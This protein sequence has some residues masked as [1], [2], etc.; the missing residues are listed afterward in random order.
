MK[1]LLLI[2]VCAWFVMTDA[3][4]QKEYRVSGKVETL[5]G[6]TLPGAHVKLTDTK[7]TDR[8]IGAST[9]ADG[10][11]S[12]PVLQGT[13]QM[14]I[15]FVGYVTYVSNVNVKG[16][17]HLPVVTLGE[18]AQLMDEVV[19]TARTVTYHSNGYVAEISKNPFYKNQDMNAILRM[20]PG[21]RV[22][23]QGLEAYGNS[24]SKVYLN[25]RELRLRG[26]ELLDY[27]QTIEGKNVKQMEVVAA[28][29]VEEDA[30]STGLA[31][32][33]ITTINPET[34]GLL[35]IGG[36][37]NYRGPNHIYGGDMNLQWRINKKWGVYGRFSKNKSN[38]ES[39]NRSETHFYETDH[40][41][42]GETEDRSKKS[43]I[44]GALGVT[45]DW[46]EN[47]LFSIEGTYNSLPSTTQGWDDTRHWNGQT[48]ENL[49]RGSSLS[50]GKVDFLNLSFLYLH[51]FG[52][53]GELTF[54]AEAYKRED[55]DK[56]ER[57]Y[58]YA[59]GE[60]QESSFLGEESNTL[61]TLKV[62]YTH[63]FSSVKGKLDAGLK[64]QW[65]ENDNYN[66]YLAFVNGQKDEYGSYMD[67]Y[68]YKDQVYAAYAKYSFDWKKFKFN[69]GV[70]VEHNRV[71]PYSAINPERNVRSNYTD[72][73]PEAGISYFIDKEKGHNTSLS[74][75]KG[76]QRPLMG[77]LNPVVLRQGEYNYYMGNPL[78]KPYATHHFSWTTHLAH[79][80]IFRVAYQQSDGGF[81]Q[82]GENKD[83]VIYSTTYNQGKS[84]SLSAYV[85]VPVRLGK[86]VRLTFDGSFSRNYLSYKED[87]RSYTHW[88]VGGSGMFMLP[89]GF[90]LMAD[91]SY[92]PVSK[93][94]YGEQYF[95]PLANLRLSKSFLNGKL[96]TALMAG[97]LFNSMD[98]HRVESYYDTYSQMSE[99]TKRSVGVTLNIRYNIRWGQ[100]S[101]VR[102]AG[103]SSGE[104]RF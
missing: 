5:S 81:L 20:T 15:S 72:F 2:V 7:Q 69:A 87:E 85:S 18:D 17:V 30:S 94:L 77:M 59:S 68:I 3:M 58:N 49:A 97:D 92:S 53:N 63:R 103:S 32:L 101:D 71:A 84:S 25:G 73:F 14:E 44:N 41:R 9:E 24:V 78:L 70:R 31:I 86:K 50:D 67:H 51:R 36:L 29:G 75:Q 21:T 19:V 43:P 57:V 27:L 80:Y 28:T 79:Q 95:R 8:M 6:A 61:Y 22:T 91:F 16:D 89:A 48:Y 12:I 40:K 90:Q 35:G 96:N 54:H 104:G 98:H 13:Y 55:E 82:L 60:K 100:K 66:N 88:R 56:Q 26:Q 47:N 34:G 45:F 99:G 33:K 10:T 74:Y 93:I 4:A 102:Q 37:G 64:A 23:F 1:H 11:F 76:V 38:F 62:D 83:G 46:D 52:K 42:I 65:L 39:G